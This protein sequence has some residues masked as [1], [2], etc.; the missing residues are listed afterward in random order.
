MVSASH[1]AHV[2]DIAQMCYAIAWSEQAFREKP[3]LSLNINHAVPPLRFDAD[4]C[5]VMAAAVQ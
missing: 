4:A 1:P 2:S 3:F 5:E